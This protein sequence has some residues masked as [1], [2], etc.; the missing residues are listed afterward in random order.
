MRW[1][2]KRIVGRRR[3]KTVLGPNKAVMDTIL[4]SLTLSKNCFYS[5]VMAQIYIHFR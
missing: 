3:D 4:K 5:V 2:L 1:K